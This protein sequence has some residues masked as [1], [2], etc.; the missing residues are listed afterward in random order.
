MASSPENQD[1]GPA[2]GVDMASDWGLDDDHFKD[3]CGVF[4]I[5][6]HE[7]AAILTA[8]GL[9][10]LQHRGQDA[11]G[12]VSFDGEHFSAELHK[13]LVGD[14]FS[15]ESGTLDNL[16]GRSA[17]G[18]VRYPTA[19]GSALKNIQPL[20]AD[21]P[22]GGIAMAHNGNLTNAALLRHDLVDHGAIFQSTSDTETILHLVATSRAKR[23]ADRLAE[24]LRQVEGAFS[25]ICLTN[26]KLI[27]VRDPNG[28]RPLVLGRLGEAHVLASETCALDIIGAHH[29][30]DV[31]PGEMVIIEAGKAPVS[32]RPFA[33]R[34][35]RFCIFEYVYFSRADSVFDGIG[36]YESRKNIGRE[37]FSESPAEADIV[38]PVPDSGVA[39]ALGYAEAAGLPFDYG[40]IKNN[41]IGR[42]FI[43][44]TEASRQHAVRLKLSPN[45][46][47]IEG[48]RV[49]L[50]DDS[51]VRGTTSVGIVQMV[52]DAGAR[53]VHMRIASP[54]T[55][56]AC[57]YGVDTPDTDKLIASQ[58]TNEGIRETIQ[59]DSL[60]YLSIDGLYRAM[61]KPARNDQDPGYCD[62]CFTRDYPIRLL[63]QEGSDRDRQLSFMQ[64]S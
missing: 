37:L 12:I 57:Y 5:I 45:R 42:T 28:I 38:C 32:V 18:H 40:I 59:A 4:G 54:P 33:P 25:L 26:K 46:S 50:V 16:P 36:V 27:G 11:A 7:D 51:I 15:A 23:V 24:A 44:P 2:T 61:G 10:A 20:Y 43:K 13:G 35:N 3:E 58:R 55:I 41:Y 64:L 47:A 29:I 39:A 22:T 1:I 14:N 60:A 9:H 30:R 49:L 8:L 6:G 48:K 56:G 52:R 53:E 19:G 21:L 17:I 63:D 62:A 31:E 34:P